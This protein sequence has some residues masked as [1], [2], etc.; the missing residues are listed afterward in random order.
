MAGIIIELLLS[1]LLLKYVAK[2]NLSVLGIIPTGK[3]WR[4]LFTGFLLPFAYLSALYITLSIVGG[5]HYKINPEYSITDFFASLTYVLRAVIFEELIFRG[6]LLYILIIRIGSAKAI[7]VSAISFGIYHWFSYGIIGQAIPML[8]A[9]LMTGIMG[10]LFA[11]AYEKTR[12]VLLPFAIH[13]GINFTGMI[14]FSRDKNIGL[15]LLVK[16]YQKDPLIPGAVISILLMI[17]YYIG[18]YLLCYLWLRKFKR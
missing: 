9:F 8:Q 1:Y 17:I 11:L 16:S 2:Q 7:L 4:Y 12:S 10:Y 5:N 14:L 13:F 3:K 15:Q 18:F 6:A